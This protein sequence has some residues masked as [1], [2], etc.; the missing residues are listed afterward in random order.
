MTPEGSA[1]P[2][3][4]ECQPSAR[5]ATIQNAVPNRTRK[6]R[7]VPSGSSCARG[8]A[9]SQSYCN[10][11]CCDTAPRGNE[12]EDEFTASK[13]RLRMHLRSPISPVVPTSI[14]SHTWAHAELASIAFSLLQGA[15]ALPVPT[16]PTVC[17]SP[18]D[19]AAALVHAGT[20]VSRTLKGV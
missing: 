12:D 7:M 13:S 10:K 20:A 4:P 15:M 16:C 8:Q 1:A 14:G 9:P 2:A 3:V 19:G 5:T 11:A 18:T 6:R 17:V